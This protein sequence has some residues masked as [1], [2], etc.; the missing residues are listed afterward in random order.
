M[1]GPCLLELNATDGYWYAALLAYS[2]YWYA[3]LRNLGKYVTFMHDS[4][5]S[6][7]LIELQCAAAEKYNPISGYDLFW[8]IPIITCHFL[9][10]PTIANICYSC[11]C[12]FEG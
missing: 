10:R 1:S 2:I 3:A 9:S 12:S 6:K 5:N 11:A 7:P 8:P 4:G